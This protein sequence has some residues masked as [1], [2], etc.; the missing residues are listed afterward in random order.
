MGSKEAVK[1]GNAG[2]VRLRLPGY[3]DMP[4]EK[5]FRA[6]PPRVRATRC[7]PLLPMFACIC[8]LGL[9]VG[10]VVGV[11]CGG[12]LWGWLWGWQWCCLWCCLW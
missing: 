12:W 8:S 5:L 2:G 6:P 4:L 9:A 7:L 11:G 1:D 10:L 3:F